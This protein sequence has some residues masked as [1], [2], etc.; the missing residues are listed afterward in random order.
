[1]WNLQ[2][3]LAEFDRAKWRI[4]KGHIERG[5]IGLVHLRQWAAAMC[6]GHLPSLKLAHALTDLRIWS[7]T[8]N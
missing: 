6:F 8:L 1:M 4:W 5:I 7:A 2:H 3:A